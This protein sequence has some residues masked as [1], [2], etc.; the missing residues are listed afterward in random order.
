MANLADNAL[1]HTPP[2][3]VI[4]IGCKSLNG[5][6]AL[7]IED[8]GAGIAAEHQGRV[9]DRFYRV[10]PGRT[11]GEGGAG[12]GLSI[13]RAIAESHGGQVSLASEPGKGARFEATF[14]KEPIRR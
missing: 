9:F 4:T 13:V 3:G 1:A 10:D 8:S 14:P 12:L 7:W 5:S 11:R 2:G 6:V